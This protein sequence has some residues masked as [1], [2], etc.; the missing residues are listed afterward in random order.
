[1]VRLW[2]HR[3]NWSTTPEL[4]LCPPGSRIPVVNAACFVVEVG[5]GPFEEVAGDDSV[6]VA[7]GDKHRD[8]VEAAGG[9][10]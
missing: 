4:R 3:D 1:L 2:S 6:G 10:G 7:V 8:P 5:P 9:G